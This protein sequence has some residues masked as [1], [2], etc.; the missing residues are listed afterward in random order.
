MMSSGFLSKMPSLVRET[1]QYSQSAK[2]QRKVAPLEVLALVITPLNQT[3]LPQMVPASVSSR[4]L[5]NLFPCGYLLQATIMYSSSPLKGTFTPVNRD[6]VLLPVD[7]LT[8]QNSGPVCSDASSTT[9][10][11]KPIATEPGG[12]FAPDL[13]TL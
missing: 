10:H 4:L 6:G 7:E 2:S 5:A 12:L 3:V 8:E 13:L 11:S 9:H 1:A